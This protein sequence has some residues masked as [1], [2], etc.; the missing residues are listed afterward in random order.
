MKF[1]AVHRVGMMTH[2]ECCVDHPFPYHV[3]GVGWELSPPPAGRGT[4]GRLFKLAFW[5]LSLSTPKLCHIDLWLAWLVLIHHYLNRLHQLPS[6]TLPRGRVS[7]SFLIGIFLW[8]AAF[9]PYSVR[10][11]AVIELSLSLSRYF[12]RVPLLFSPLASHLAV[13]AAISLE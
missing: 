6:A 5:C 2:R 8:W 3:T 10:L 12:M 1:V 7:S 9:C 13:S 11:R 4:L